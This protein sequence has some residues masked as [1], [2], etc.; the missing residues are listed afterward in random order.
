MKKQAALGRFVREGMIVYDIGAN[1]GFDTLLFSKLV[2]PKGHVFSFEPFPEN[3]FHLLRHIQLNGLRNVAVINAAIAEKDRLASFHIAENNS[4]GSISKDQSIFNVPTLSIDQFIKDGHPTPDLIKMD[5]EGG[6][7]LA[8]QGAEELL[9]KREAL[10]FIA[11]H[12]D[13]A[14]QRCSEMLNNV[15][16]E[17]FSMEGQRIVDFTQNVDEIYA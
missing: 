16:Y 8:M 3:A 17:A 15:R 14:R 11:L 4:S 7:T 5:I 1:A 2:G 6:E 10:W 13:E 9:S 12:N